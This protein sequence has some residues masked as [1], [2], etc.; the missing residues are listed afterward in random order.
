MNFILVF[1]FFANIACPIKCIE[2]RNKLQ[3]KQLKNNV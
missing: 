3:N 2:R 1:M